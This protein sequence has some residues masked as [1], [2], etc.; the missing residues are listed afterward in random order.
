MVLSPQEQ[1]KIAEDERRFIAMRWAAYKTIQAGG[2]Y[3]VGDEKLYK[4]I[5]KRLKRMF[6]GNEEKLSRFK[7]ISDEIYKDRAHKFAE[8]LYLLGGKLR[9]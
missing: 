4:S 5:R 6:M 7:L 9:K 2:T 8:F 1:A 3:S